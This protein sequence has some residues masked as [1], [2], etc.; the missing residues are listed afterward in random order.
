M[1]HYVSGII[2]L[3]I[4]LF[5]SACNIEENIDI[6]KSNLTIS[7]SASRYEFDDNNI[8]GY[9]GIIIDS[10]F[11]CYIFN[12]SS[13]VTKNFL[14]NNNMKIW[15]KTHGYKWKSMNWKLVENELENMLIVYCDS[16]DYDMEQG[17]KFSN[18]YDEDGYSLDFN[19][20]DMIIY[21]VKS[22]EKPYICINDVRNVEKYQYFDTGKWS[23]I[24]DDDLCIDYDV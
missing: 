5:C 9:K 23:D 1:K 4:V 11:I 13:E 14:D 21:E 12:K 3:C 16:K 2:V 18:C 7:D 22:V 17:S 19:V 20:K 24:F 6:N 15:M 8:L 10:G